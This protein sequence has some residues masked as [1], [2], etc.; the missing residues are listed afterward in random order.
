[1]QNQ[2]G[3]NQR[4]YEEW[5]NVGQ[6]V[7]AQ[8]MWICVYLWCWPS[9]WEWTEAEVWVAWIICKVGLWKSESDGSSWRSVIHK[10]DCF[11]YCCGSQTAI[12]N[13]AFSELPFSMLQIDD[14][15]KVLIFFYKK[16]CSELEKTLKLWIQEMETKIHHADDWPSVQKIQF[17]FSVFSMPWIDIVV[18]EEFS[19][20]RV[21]GY[22]K[23]VLWS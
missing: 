16:P 11:I 19:Y 22:T 20:W 7:I 2:S 12:Q 6:Q 18:L 15:T 3:S 5:Q 4:A 9:H 21:L 14:T 17:Q 10:C 1:M 23:N 13:G 8:Y